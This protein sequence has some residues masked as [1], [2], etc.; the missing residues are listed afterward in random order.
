MPFHEPCRVI[1]VS[2]PAIGASTR[3]RRSAE[4]AASPSPMPVIAVNSG[5][6]KPE[7]TI[8]AKK[9]PMTCATPPATP[10]LCAPAAYPLPP[11]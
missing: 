7:N 4:R 3:T 6:A 10:A 11:R 5:W 9:I 1:A 8:R 2:Q